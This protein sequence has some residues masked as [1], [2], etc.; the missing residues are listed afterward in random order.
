MT[1]SPSS[2]VTAI[3]VVIRSSDSRLGPERIMIRRR[4]VRLSESA[5]PGA[6]GPGP[7]L[8]RHTAGPAGHTKNERKKSKNLKVTLAA[9]LNAPRLRIDVI[10]MHN[11]FSA[12]SVQVL[13]SQLQKSG[14]VAK[15]QVDLNPKQRGGDRQKLLQCV[16]ISKTL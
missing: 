15:A 11:L 8:R 3:Q 7:R 9:Q 2:A 4:R 12:L 16:S 5:G 6:A 10:Y 1:Q 14:I 13:I